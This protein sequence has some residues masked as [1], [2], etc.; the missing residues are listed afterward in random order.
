MS[1]KMEFKI[2]IVA[3]SRIGKTSLVTALLSDSQKLL[4]GTPV[5]IKANDLKTT[6]KINQ[7]KSELRGS[8]REG[9]FNTGA[10][11]GTQESFEF[12]LLLKH[13][14]QDDSNGMVLRLLDFPGG[15]MN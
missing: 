2:G 9:E 5:V 4:A 11:Q 15:W 3:P 7:H 1:K 13:T 14:E 8:L 6:A 10:M 12:N